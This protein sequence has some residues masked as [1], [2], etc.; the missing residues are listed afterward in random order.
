MP[1]WWLEG[2]VARG[3]LP[4][5]FARRHGVQEA[6]KPPLGG[7]G[8]GTLCQPCKFTGASEVIHG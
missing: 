3:E 5:A 4:K 8:P 7:M 1:D 6:M 2:E